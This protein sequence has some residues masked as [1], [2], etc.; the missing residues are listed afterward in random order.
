MRSID[1]LL[2]PEAMMM[3][4]TNDSMISRNAMMPV[5][6]PFLKNVAACKDS[7]DQTYRALQAKNYQY[8]LKKEP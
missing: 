5:M 6:S 7:T 4:M 8:D 2:R 1:S 3:T